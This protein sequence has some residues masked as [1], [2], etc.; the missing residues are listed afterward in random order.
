MEEKDKKRFKLEYN[1]FNT[2][3]A[4]ASL[5]IA[6]IALVLV[7]NQLNLQKKENRSNLIGDYLILEKLFFEIEQLRH[8]PENRVFF[9]NAH[10]EQTIQ[11]L[12]D[13]KHIVNQGVNNNLLKMN[14]K[15]YSRWWVFYKQVDFTINT[16]SDEILITKYYNISVNRGFAL[17]GVPVNKND[18]DME[19]LEDFKNYLKTF[20]IKGVENLLDIKEIKNYREMYNDLS[21]Y[22]RIIRE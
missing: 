7:S 1:R 4:F 16:L 12:K 19:T 3:I 14:N 5:I 6:T 15:I 9:E 13:L 8:I 11:Y 21:N 22:G 17:Y 10:K 20:W 2:I 18:F